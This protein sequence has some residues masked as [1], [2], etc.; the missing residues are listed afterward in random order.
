MPLGRSVA[1]GGAKFFIP[2]DGE[3]AK[4]LDQKPE[5]TGKPDRSASAPRHQV[6]VVG[7]DSTPCMSGLGKN[8][9][10]GADRAGF[11]PVCRQSG[12]DSRFASKLTH[13]RG[14][15]SLRLNPACVLYFVTCLVPRKRLEV[16]V[17][18]GSDPASRDAFFS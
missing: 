15:P 12:N 7:G 11:S 6:G 1:R 9:A 10:N 14:K 4:G 8:N 5:G 2:G 18:T 3:D 16:A 17:K 13:Q